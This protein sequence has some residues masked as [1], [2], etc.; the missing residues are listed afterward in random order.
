MYGSCINPIP[1]IKASIAA[2]MRIVLTTF[3]KKGEGTKSIFFITI[4]D[5]I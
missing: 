5:L 3:L 4:K 1:Y 2:M